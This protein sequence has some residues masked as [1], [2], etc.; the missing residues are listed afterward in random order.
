MSNTIIEARDVSFRYDGA[1]EDAV[2]HVS[3]TVA[4]GEFVAVL[5]RNGSGK[6]TFAKLLNA[7][8]LPTGGKLT[9]NGLQP[10]SEDDC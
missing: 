8:L 7:L 9:V 1:A 5:G 2:S 6:S 10:A 4:R 3:L